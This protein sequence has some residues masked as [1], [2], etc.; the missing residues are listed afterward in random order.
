[1]GDYG[2]QRQRHGVTK[3]L[4]EGIGGAIVGA[5]LVILIGTLREKRPRDEQRPPP[6]SMD[7]TEEAMQRQA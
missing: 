2:K 5:A 4:V 1:M 3:N 7:A 6:A